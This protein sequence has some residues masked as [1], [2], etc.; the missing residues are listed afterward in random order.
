[1]TCYLLCA[2]FSVYGQATAPNTDEFEIVGKV[3][4]TKKITLADLGKYPTQ[5]LADVVIT[6]HLGEKKGVAKQLRGVLVLDVLKSVDFQAETPR[7]L[8]EFYLTF[9]GADG[10]KAVFSWN[11][12]F[13]SPTGKNLYFITEKAGQP[14]TE[15]EDRIILIAPNDFKTGRRFVKRLAKIVVDRVQ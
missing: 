12:I 2:C 3:N 14:L 11:E 15:M 10:Y 1:M 8:S 4:T 5:N 13:N 7:V 6:N 9:I